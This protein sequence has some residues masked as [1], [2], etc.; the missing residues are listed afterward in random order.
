MK[1]IKNTNEI[2]KIIND[3]WEKHEK[4]HRQNFLLKSLFGIENK[5][6]LTKERKFIRK[7]VLG[8]VKNENE[9]VTVY[10]I[11]AIKDFGDVKKGELG[12]FVSDE[13][14]ISPYGNSWVYGDAILVS[15]YIADNVKVRN[16]SMVVSSFLTDNVVI[17]EGSKI[18]NKSVIT[19][20]TKIG[21]N[22]TVKHSVISGS[23]RISGESTIKE[24]IISNKILFLI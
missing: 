14:C 1:E 22:I 16:N 4:E 15:S 8:A 13:Y 21:G 10:R 2:T 6:I 3:E 11:Q 19:D 23:S 18:F 5:Y 17:E 24:E 12:G 7:K 9:F 20:D